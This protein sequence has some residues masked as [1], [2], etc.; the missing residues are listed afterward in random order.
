MKSRREDALLL[1]GEGVIHQTG[2]G[3]LE[4]FL[5]EALGSLVDG[6]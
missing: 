6:V 5:G 3:S 2:V 1:G 4:N